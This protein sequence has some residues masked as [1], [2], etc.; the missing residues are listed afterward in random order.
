MIVVSDKSRTA[1]IS[2]VELVNQNSDQPVPIIEVAEARGVPLHVVE[3]L[4]GSL[5]RA[6]ILQSQRGMRGGYSFRKPPSEVTVLDVVE[7]VDGELASLEAMGQGLDSVW[8]EALEGL[9]ATLSGA[10][11]AELAHRDAEARSAPMF[12]I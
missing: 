12:H 7:A 4:F 6:G 10:T 3:Q 2:L 5:R 11:V 8:R 1:L 9:S